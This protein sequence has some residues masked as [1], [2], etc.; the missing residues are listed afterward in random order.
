MI[1]SKAN[2]LVVGACTPK[3]HEPVFK[4]VLESMGIDSSYL[5][6]ANIREHSSFVH[7]QDREGARKVAE[8]IIRSAVARASVLERVLVKE[9]DITRKT[10]VIGGGVSGLSAAIDLAEEGYEVHLVE[11][12]PT[13][14]GKMAKLDRTFPTDD[15]SI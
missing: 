1:E 2:R 15:C 11:R 7:R 12:S 14:G 3:T 6:F 5:E 8:D 10:L 4:S 13:I 9:V